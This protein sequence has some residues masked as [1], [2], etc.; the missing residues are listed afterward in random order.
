MKRLNYLNK[1]VSGI[2]LIALIISIIVLLILA[3]ISIAIVKE[4]LIP[5][6]VLAAAKTTESFLQEKVELTITEANMTFQIERRQHPNLDKILFYETYIKSCLEKSNDFENVVVSIDKNE[7][8]NISYNYKSQNYKFFIPKS[9][10]VNLIQNL[11]GNVRVGD[12]I[13]YPIEYT[14]VFSK[15]KYLPQNNAWCVIYDGTS[16]INSNYVKI[17]STGIPVKYYHN[18]SVEE[19]VR[20]FENNFEAVNLRDN[21][22]NDL[23]GDYFW[24]KNLATKVKVL[25]LEELNYAYNVFHKTSRTLLSTDL[26][27]ITDTLFYTSTRSANYWLG[28]ANGNDLMYVSHEKILSTSLDYR[29]GIRVVVYLKDN[30]TGYYENGI[31]KI[32]N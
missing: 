1:N 13:E 30:L 26:L 3:G 31:W 18:L 8:I 6:A 21:E 5:H 2:T 24:N 11:K 15:Q 12:Y 19:T 23:T 22:L 32:V 14:D 9:G 25:N 10:S 29:F 4:L 16:E 7:N 27:D 28:T 17:V 20:K